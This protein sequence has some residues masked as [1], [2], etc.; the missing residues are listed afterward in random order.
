MRCKTSAEPQKRFTLQVRNLKQGASTQAVAF[1]QHGQERHWIERPSFEAGITGWHDSHLD[2]AAIQHIPQLSPA[3]LLQLNLNER[4][5]AL[6]PRKKICQKILDRLGCG[7]DA[8]Q[9]SLPCL[10][11]S[12]PLTKRADVCQQTAAMS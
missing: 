9:T 8:Q 5:P 3:C 6:I 1:R 7:A 4:M 11:G 10:Q 2:L 12:R